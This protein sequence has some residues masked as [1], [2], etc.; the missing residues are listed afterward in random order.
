MAKFRMKG[1]A[2]HIYDVVFSGSDLS[3]VL[4]LL[5]NYTGTVLAAVL[6]LLLL[7]LLGLFM[8]RLERPS[9][10]PLHI[11]ALP[12]IVMGASAFA[13]FPM[14]NPKEEEYLPFLA[15]YNASALPLSL[16]NVPDLVGKPSL[17]ERISKAKA[18]PLPDTVDCRPTAKKPDFILVLAESQTAPEFL[19]DIRLDDA[20]AETFRSGD[21]RLNSLYVETVSGG[22]WMT[23][24]S[25]LTGLSTADFGWQAAY[26]TRTMQGKV[27]G[28]LPDVLSRCGYRTIAIMPMESEAMN[29]GPFLKSVGF[30]EVYDA[31]R[32]GHPPLTVRDSAYFDFAEALIAKHR[33]TDGRPLFIEIQTMFAHSPYDSVLLPG[34]SSN[35]AEPYTAD[36]QVNEYLRRV[37]HARQDLAD[38]H[39]RRKRDPG[40]NG[41]LVAEFGDHHSYATR[42]MTLEKHGQH[43]LSDFRSPIYRTYFSVRNYGTPFDYGVLR[44]AED[45]AFL[46]AR[47]MQGSAL[48]RS[49]IFLELAKI[50][51]ACSGRFF[52]CAD[53]PRVDAH[54][55]SRLSAGTIAL[56]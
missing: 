40:P 39:E 17:H 9:R 22:T 53:R 15:G 35:T 34:K 36:A 28:S 11:R 10:M 6:A 43:S 46:T 7:C 49:P 5:E 41:T 1:L 42:P 31:R 37:V 12:M 45:A 56:R 26:V 24:F 4:F 21:G 50:S 54:L 55:K 16:W 47:L 25:V 38:F 51:D 48:P 18:D 3:V 33:K 19:P 30:Q 13:M 8:Y 29:E 2:L 14:M 27:R 23:N 52:T 44:Q 20:V 32:L